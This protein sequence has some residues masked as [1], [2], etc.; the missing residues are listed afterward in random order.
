[1]RAG[2]PLEATG[3]SCE[4]SELH[5][6]PVGADRVAADRR[7]ASMNWSSVRKIGVG[8]ESASKVYTRATGA[9]L[10][11][12]PGSGRPRAGAVR[13]LKDPSCGA[14]G[15]R[16]AYEPARGRV[17]GWLMGLPKSRNR[18]LRS[19]SHQAGVREQ[20]PLAG[21]A[22]EHAH[23]DARTPDVAPRGGRRLRSSRSDRASDRLAYYGGHTQVE[24]RANWASRGKPSKRR[25]Q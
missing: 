20:E 14:G 25:T 5:V 2:P 19:R 1:M 21:L 17:P 22:S 6:R 9:Y 4:W 18:L 7:R 3:A 13:C 15:G 10:T 8:E 24:Q 16:E 11:A 12:R 23:R